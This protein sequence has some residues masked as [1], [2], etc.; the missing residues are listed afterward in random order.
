MFS[1]GDV[2]VYIYVRTTADELIASLQQHEQQIILTSHVR[3]ETNAWITAHCSAKR[4]ETE[5][6]LRPETQEQP[7]IAM[8]WK[9]CKHGLMMTASRMMGLTT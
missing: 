8:E 4:S 9:N 6:D 7:E 5:Q 3:A 2:C 1:L